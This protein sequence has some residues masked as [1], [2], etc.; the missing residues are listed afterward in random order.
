[1]T[2]YRQFSE[3]IQNYGENAQVDSQSLST[4]PLLQILRQGVNLQTQKGTF[5]LIL[6]VAHTPYTDLY[7]RH[8]TWYMI[9]TK[10][11]VIKEECKRIYN[12][13]CMY[14]DLYL[15]H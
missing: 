6:E 13:M 14:L 12:K 2:T 5:G 11:N 3:N 15:V 7:C 9:Q 10:D 8:E 1:M 4:K